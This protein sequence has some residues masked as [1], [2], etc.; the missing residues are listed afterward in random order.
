MKR[1]LLFAIAAIMGAA[2]LWAQKIEVVDTDGNPVPYAKIFDANA[3]CIGMTSLD[4]VLLDAKGAGEV[5]IQHVAFKSKEVKLSGQDVR[6]VLEDADF[7]LEELVVSPKP[8]VYVQTYYRVYFYSEKDG[9]YYYRAG[10]TDNYYDKKTKKL[11]THTEHLSKGFLGI[12]TK[13]INTILGP[14]LNR[15]S[16]INMQ[17]R[18]EALLRSGKVIQL[19]I[20][21][22]GPGKKDITDCKGLVGTITD[23]KEM[24][25]RCFVIDNS[26]IKLHIFEARGDTK[27][28]EKRQKREAR[29]EKRGQKNKETTHYEIYAIDSEGNYAPEDLVVHEFNDTYD[30]EEDGKVYHNIDGIQVFATDRAYVTKEE[31]KQR[32]K[33]NKMKM[34]YQNIREFERQHNIPPLAPVVQKKLD[35]LW[36]KRGGN[37]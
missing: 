19:K 24:G 11:Q 32:R 21:Q 14:A 34:T 15:C 23:D 30:S 35:E 26:L 31:L 6:I 18:E 25:Q 29:I 8:L 3:N 7:E 4:G 9:I 16:H 2:G 22:T 33:D 36:S 27:E 28:I 5:S 17:N 12:A 1:L 20:T 10:L 37:F 13:T